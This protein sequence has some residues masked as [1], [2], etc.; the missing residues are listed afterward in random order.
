MVLN[1]ICWFT[2]AVPLAMVL[3]KGSL[4]S[5]ETAGLLG[6]VVLTLLS[7]A[8]VVSPTAMVDVLP[9]L[10]MVVPV[11]VVVG[12]TVGGMGVGEVQATLVVPP[13]QPVE[14]LPMLS[15]VLFTQPPSVTDAATKAKPQT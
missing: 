1:Q 6:T 9:V 12:N 7:K 13:L 14:R 2:V 4:P 10:T 8:I 15:N 3:P 11:G 5:F